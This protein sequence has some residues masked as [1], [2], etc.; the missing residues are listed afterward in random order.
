MKTI[1]TVE[2]EH[3]ERADSSTSGRKHAFRRLAVALVSCRASQDTTNATLTAWGAGITEENLHPVAGTMAY[4]SR[5]ST[6]GRTTSANGCA[7]R[8]RW[9][10][11]RKKGVK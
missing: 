2:R 9:K 8:G 10:N 4:R 6:S 7:R 1:R 5:S 11:R 3:R